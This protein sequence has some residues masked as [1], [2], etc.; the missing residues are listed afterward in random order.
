MKNHRLAI[1]SLLF[2]ALFATSHGAALAQTAAAQAAPPP[3]STY[4]APIGFDAARSAGAAAVAEAERNGW[5]MSI[6]IVD[7]AGQL[8]HF[9]KMDNSGGA[10]GPIAIEKAKSSAL[11][12]RP[13]K[14]FQDGIAA[15][16]MF[17]LGMPGAVPVGG[18]F[19]LVADGKV[20]GGIGVSG[21][22]GAQDEAVARAAADQLK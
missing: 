10:T 15:G 9:Q 14:F 11:F 21:G 19:P 8:V 4:G 1:S 3:P 5:K 12:R 2:A 18:G 6:A 7:P 20:V 22:T 16:N 13:T 17:W